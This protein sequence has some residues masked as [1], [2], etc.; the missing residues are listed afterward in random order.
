MSFVESRSADIGNICVE[1][2][3]T[4]PVLVKAEARPQ[5]PAQVAEMAVPAH[6]APAMPYRHDAAPPPDIEDEADE[7]SYADENLP[8]P[9]P[10]FYDIRSRDGY[11]RRAYGPPPGW[12]SYAPPP[13]RYGWYP[14]DPYSR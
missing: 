14:R 9:P 11:P 1:S 6:G 10:R 5:R 2:R 3:P 8:P 4:P 12:R 7:L 13:P